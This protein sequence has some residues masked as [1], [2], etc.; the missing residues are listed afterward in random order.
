MDIHVKILG[1]L[2]IVLGLLGVLAAGFIFF[3]VAGAGWISGDEVAI[4]IT[5]LVAVAIAAVSVLISAPGIVAGIGLLNFQ[6]W[7]RILALVLGI[8]NL[9]GFPLGTI[10]GIYSLVILL[11]DRTSELFPAN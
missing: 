7:A 10:L 9:P 5:T 3:V 1:W 4:R 11:D 2:Y 6:P 8:L